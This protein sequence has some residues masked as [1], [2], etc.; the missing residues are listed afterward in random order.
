MLINKNIEK[1]PG[2]ARCKVW[3]LA[4]VDGRISQDILNLIMH[5]P[6]LK[7]D[8]IVCLNG[9]NEIAS[10]YMLNPHIA[11]EMAFLFSQ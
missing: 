3:N 11:Q 5:G 9:W 7:P 10:S 8:L 1:F 2:K 6:S 4:Q